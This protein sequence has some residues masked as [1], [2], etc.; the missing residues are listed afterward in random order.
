MP[1]SGDLKTKEEEQRR[2]QASVK[3]YYGKELKRSEDVKSGISCCRQ[4]IPQRLKEAVALVHEEVCA[5]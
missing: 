3:Q 1:A 4:V 5:K 2:L